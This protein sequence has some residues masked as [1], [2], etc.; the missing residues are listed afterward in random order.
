M[1][2]TKRHI[3][4]YAAQLPGG[5][6]QTR[7]R[8]LH[9]PVNAH[10]LFNYV[11]QNTSGFSNFGVEG[12][13]HEFG[14]TQERLLSTPLRDPSGQELRP[15]LGTDAL[16]SSGSKTGFRAC[17]FPGDGTGAREKQRSQRSPV[18]MGVGSIV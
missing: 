11:C 5:R 8:S 1:Q 2:S 13:P 7:S 17:F 4:P 10:N 14:G 18:S 16:F 3:V 12:G 6:E 15:K 9:D